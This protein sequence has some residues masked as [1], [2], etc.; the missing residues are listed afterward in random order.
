M[1]RRGFDLASRRAQIGLAAGSVKLAASRRFEAGSSKNLGNAAVTGAT[2]RRDLAH[3]VRAV[4]A[5]RG[6]ASGR[7]STAHAR[8][9]N[10]VAAFQAHAGISPV[11]GLCLVRRRHGLPRGRAVGHRVGERRRN[12]EAGE[13][14]SE[15]ES[16][17]VLPVNCH[18]SL[19][20]AEG[21]RKHGDS[22]T[23]NTHAKRHG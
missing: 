1:G 10:L 4:L 6:R 8:R 18:P 3:V 2:A 5:A 9:G 16:H 21:S 17:V 20:P 14:T 13:C 19:T 23:S 11:A 22:C 12:E 7:S 15:Q